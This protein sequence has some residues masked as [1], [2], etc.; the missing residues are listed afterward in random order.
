MNALE[1]FTLFHIIMTHYTVKSHLPFRFSLVY[2]GR[3]NFCKVSQNGENISAAVRV[4]S[5][6]FVAQLQAKALNLSMVSCKRQHF[7]IRP[8]KPACY[9]EN[10]SQCC[11]VAATTAFCI[12]SCRC[13]SP[14]SMDAHNIKTKSSHIQGNRS[15]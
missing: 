1:S 7:F 3:A 2:L 9:V 5:F 12:K 10:H 11:L 14:Q 8:E 13:L 4:G 6:S 15:S